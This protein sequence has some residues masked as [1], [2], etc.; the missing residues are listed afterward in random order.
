MATRP[1]HTVELFGFPRLLAGQAAVRIEGATLAEIAGGLGAACPS[2]L[3]Q[4][5]DR[6]TGWLLPGYVFVVG[7][8]FTSNRE[9]AVDPSAAVLLVSAAAGG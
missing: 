9:L 8:R 1:G 3:G 7:D 4:V 2:L 6:D 5:I